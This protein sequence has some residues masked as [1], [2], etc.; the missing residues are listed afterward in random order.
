MTQTTP[1]GSAQQH[2]APAQ[3]VI[4]PIPHIRAAGVHSFI[5]GHQNP[6]GVRGEAAAPQT[7][8]SAAFSEAHPWKVSCFSV[9][10]GLASFIGE[11]PTAPS[12]PHSF[13]SS[14]PTPVSTTLQ[15]PTCPRK[16]H[17]SFEV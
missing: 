5:Q 9:G 6:T 3:G 4:K 12:D 11:T 15:H 2:Q 10:Q 13:I 1:A 17:R 16:F 14:P 7:Q 8:P